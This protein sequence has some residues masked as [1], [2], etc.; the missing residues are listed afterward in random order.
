MKKNV[1]VL[2]MVAFAAFGLNAQNY[3]WNFSIPEDFPVVAGYTDV[4][5]IK[6]LTLHPMI[7][8][9]FGAITAGTATV[10]GISYTHR[11]QFNGGGYS[12]SSDAH[13]TPPA[14]MPTQR[15]VSFPVNGDVTVDVVGTTGSSTSDRKIFMTD[16]TNYI[17]A[18]DYAAADGKLKRTLNYTGGATTLYLFCNAACNVYHIIVT[19]QSA[20]T[21]AIW[22]AS[23]D[24]A[25]IITYQPSVAIETGIPGLTV[26]HND[27]GA[28]PVADKDDPTATT[29]AYGDITW[30]NLA[31]IQGNTNGMFY[32]LSADADGTLDVSVKMGSGKK[33]FVAETADPIATVAAQTITA[34]D[35]NPIGKITSPTFPPVYDTHNDN[36]GTWDNT[37]AINTSGD[38]AYLVMSFPV[39]AGKT[40]IVGCDGSKLMLRGLAYIPGGRGTSIP[41]LNTNKVV[42]SIEYYDL[43]GRKVT[44]ENQKNAIL[45]QK[46]TYTDGSISSS[47]VITSKY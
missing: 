28:T 33:T 44:N 12:G 7:G 1:L 9:N 11:F 26:M 15:Y 32:A 25:N 20:P 10:D 31:F 39:V 2:V 45:I 38:N 21:P 42:K 43:M 46:V 36:T 13:L 34:S 27:A 17:G 22:K 40:Y 14:N 30:D 8:T 4:T 35:N 47:K 29:V 18:F 6:G 23:Y 37:V 19:G 3:D 5:T 24:A 41:T 16:G